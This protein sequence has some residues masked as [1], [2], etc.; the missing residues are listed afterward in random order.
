MS[1]KRISIRARRAVSGYLFILPFIIGFLCFML[2]PL[3]DSFWMSLCR[4]DVTAGQGFQTTFIGQLFS[5]HDVASYRKQ[6][7]VRNDN[8]CLSSF[9]LATKS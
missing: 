1:G 7:P 6:H 9:P 8:Y 5:K 4:V 3:V 2:L